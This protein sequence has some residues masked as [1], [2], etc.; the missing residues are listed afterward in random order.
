MHA[1]CER[2]QAR[3]R[4][5]VTLTAYLYVAGL[6]V[7]VHLRGA[8]GYV[9]DMPGCVFVCAYLCAC[10]GVCVFGFQICVHPIICAHEHERRQRRRER[11]SPSFSNLGFCMF[12]PIGDSCC[13]PLP[14]VLSSSQVLG[15]L[16]YSR[17]SSHLH[18]G[19]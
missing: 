16:S 12:P 2:L 13:S 19:M 10:R 7:H 6:C 11:E 17:K 9:M 8:D 1:V 5:R 18:G 4:W 15:T 14:P 3:A